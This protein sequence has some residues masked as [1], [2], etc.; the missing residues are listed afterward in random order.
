MQIFKKNEFKE[1]LQAQIE[2]INKYKRMRSK[3]EG[4]DIGRNRACEEWIVKGYA[5]NFRITWE[6]NHPIKKISLE[7]E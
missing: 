1:F 2:E 3:E 4:C 5:E 7:Q 6:Q